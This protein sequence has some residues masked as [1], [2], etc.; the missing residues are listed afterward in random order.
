MLRLWQTW[1]RISW[2]ITRMSLLLAFWVPERPASFRN[3]SD[4]NW[5]KTCLHDTVLAD[6]AMQAALL[7]PVPPTI[8]TSAPLAL[9]VLHLHAGGT[10]RDVDNTAKPIMDAF[11]ARLYRDDKQVRNLVFRSWTFD[12]EAAHAAL[13]ANETFRA[14]LRSAVKHAKQGGHRI[15]HLTFVAFRDLDSAASHSATGSAAAGLSWDQ[16]RSVFH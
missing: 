10:L 13:Q 6:E 3:A 2:G 9:E 4:A 1:P 14:F 16:V 7:H 5:W 11:N 12:C 8:A 15:E